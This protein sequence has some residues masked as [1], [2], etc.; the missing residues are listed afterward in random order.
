MNRLKN[1]DCSSVIITN[2]KGEVLLQKKDL[3][4]ARNPGY[5]ALFGGR[6]GSREDPSSALERELMEELALKIPARIFKTYQYKE[7]GRKGFFYVYAGRY[8]KQLSSIKLGEGAGFAFFDKKELRYLK[9]IPADALA[10]R[11]FFKS[12]L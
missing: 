8:N 12:I 3:S 7:K 9:I 4:Y 2:K 10:L 1:V 6:I 11:D 5:W